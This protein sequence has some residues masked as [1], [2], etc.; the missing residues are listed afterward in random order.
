MINP[1]G[2]DRDLSDNE[3]DVFAVFTTNVIGTLER[4]LGRSLSVADKFNYLSS[5]EK[6]D[7]LIRTHYTDDLNLKKEIESLL[8]VDS[9]YFNQITASSVAHLLKLINNPEVKDNGS[10]TGN[11]HA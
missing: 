7:S 5:K 1:N 4:V 8:I 6:I 9:N 3:A 10:E 2:I 11:F